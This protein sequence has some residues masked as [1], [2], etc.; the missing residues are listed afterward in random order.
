MKLMVKEHF[1]FIYRLSILKGTSV[2]WTIPCFWPS[3]HQES[4]TQPTNTETLKCW[5]FCPKKRK[6]GCC[7]SKV[8][9]TKIILNM[10]KQ[11]IAKLL[12]EDHMLIQ[13]S[14]NKSIL[15]KKPLFKNCQWIL[16][17]TISHLFCLI[18]IIFYNMSVSFM[19]FL[20]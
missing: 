12:W 6:F 11:R 20:K 10:P 16:I 15:K 5:R 17:G 19:L 3:G 8:S 2:R 18:S 4:V 7:I 1:F 9:L 13:L 14:T